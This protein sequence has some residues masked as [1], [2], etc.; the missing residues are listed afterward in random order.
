[1]VALAVVAR[2]LRRPAPRERPPLD[3][4]GA[5]LLVSALIGFAPFG[6]IVHLPAFLRVARGAPAAQA[7]LVITALV[8]GVI[9]TTTVPG[10]LITRTGRY[11]GFVAPLLAPACVL[12]IALPAQPLRETAPVSDP[13]GSV[14][15]GSDPSGRSAR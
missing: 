2:K 6:T 10:R 8:A 5:V 9:A 13:S 1:M 12:S 14:P 11:L 4:L 7:G 3:V 15:S